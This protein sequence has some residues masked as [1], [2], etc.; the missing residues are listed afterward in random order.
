MASEPLV[1][2]EIYKQIP[3]E[4]R[5][6]EACGKE[7]QRNVFLL[8]GKL[9]HWGCLKTTK[10]KPTHRCMDCWS[11]LTPK[12]IVRTDFGDGY[13]TQTC[14]NCGSENL[15]KLRRS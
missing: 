5:I 3:K 6:C 14:G 11:F 9:Y 7:I 2:Q 15:R 4:N 1:L 13:P 8:D 10:A 12:G